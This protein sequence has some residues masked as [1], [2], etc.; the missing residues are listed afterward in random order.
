MTCSY[1]KEDKTLTGEHLI[2]MALID[3]FPECDL[4]YRNESV[5]KG[6]KIV[7]NDVCE[8]CNNVILSQLDDYGS[9]LIRENFLKNYEKDD[10]LDFHYDHQKLSRW[11][12]KILYNNARSLK[13]NTSWYESNLDYILGKTDKTVMPFSLFTGIA[14]DM[15][16]L[17]EFFMDNKKLGIYFEPTIVGD[18]IL[19]V[20]NPVELKF[21]R[22]KNI[23]ITKFP[24]LMSTGLVRFGSGMFLVF[25][26]EPDIEV[27]R[28]SDFEKGIEVMY[29]YTC[30]NP[31][32]GEVEIRRVTHAYNFHH[33]YLIDTTVGL[34]IADLTN[35][36]L[37]TNQN[38]VE[39]RKKDSWLWDNHVKQVRENR[40]TRRKKER[41]KRKRNKK[42]S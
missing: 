11:I 24:N 32:L 21:K 12:L 5:F 4:N 19:E 34:E 27:S 9:K 42:K 1:C 22:R 15:T 39:N 38:P 29:P 31:D 35:C 2:P 14:V 17:P 6:D 26:W 37:P 25:L 23:E 40:A 13:I 28:K 16:P 36:F 10:V 8:N 20:I 7:I 41:E 3:T 33:P 18:S 30:L